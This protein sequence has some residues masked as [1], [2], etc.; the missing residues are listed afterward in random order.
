MAGI[1]LASSWWL[2]AAE[3]ERALSGAA[4]TTAQL[5]TALELYRGDFLE[6]FFVDSQAFEEWTRIERERL[7]YLAID[8]LDTLITRHLGQGAYSAGIT[9]ASRLLQMDNLREETH[10]QLME[11]LAL[12]GQREAALAQYET[13]RRLLNDEL[14]VLPTP[15]TTALYERIRSGQLIRDRSTGNEIVHRTDTVSSRPRHNLPVQTTPFVGR[16]AE[17]ADLARLFADP[18]VRLVTILGPG[19]MGKTRLA[20]EA[21]AAQ[22]DHFTHGVF[23]VPLAALP[24]PADIARALADAI[25]LQFEGGG[26]GS[27]HR[28]AQQQLLDYFRQKHQLLVMDNFEHLLEGADLLTA[29]LQAAPGVRILAT[30][31]ERLHLSS[32]TVFTLGGMAFPGLDSPED[33]LHYDSVQLFLQSARRVRR[34]FDLCPGDLPSVSLIH[35]LVGGMPLGLRLAAGWVDQFSLEEIV[36]ELS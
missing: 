4:Q 23:F 18:T 17:L 16:E 35:H 20:I 11:L 2:D 12:A 7:H 21:A 31:R 14:S 29:I 19:G 1:N 10:R 6:G 15:E 3:F 34:D 13:C 8:A 36:Q 28:N 25:G 22:L 30:S 32:E 26:P 9:C 5:E 27:E 24:T 33:A